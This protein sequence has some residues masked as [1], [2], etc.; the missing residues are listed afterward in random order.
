MYLISIGP[1][2]KVFGGMT[3]GRDS[4]MTGEQQQQPKRL[5]K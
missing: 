5:F 1:Q 2:A 4:Q 3:S